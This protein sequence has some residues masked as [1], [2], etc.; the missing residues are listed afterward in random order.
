MGDVVRVDYLRSRFLFGT[1]RIEWVSFDCYGTLIDWET[2]I[3]RAVSAV[4]TSHEVKLS[5]DEI[6]SRF[7]EAEPFVQQ[8]SGYVKYRDVLRCVMGIIGNDLGIQLTQSEAARLADS[9]PD[10]PVFPDVVAALKTLQS[11]YKLA[12]ISNTDDDLF[13]ATA[14]A[15]GID[16][17]VV[18]TAQQVRSYKP[19][20]K[21]FLVALERMG[22]Q[23]HRWMHVAESLYHDIAPANKLGIASVWVNRSNRGGG[24]R[25][26]DAV[27]DLEVSNL[28]EL[29]ARMCG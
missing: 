11:R 1:D 20:L 7:S 16:F 12:V 24:T 9:L 29:S 21:N 15:I 23:R 18:V 22:I 28:A 3:C 26:I 19:D 6:L 8:S 10:W 14:K 25:H 5:D 13:S 4:L 2:G 27:A 17:D